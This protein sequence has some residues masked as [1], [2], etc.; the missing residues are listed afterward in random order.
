MVGMLALNMVEHAHA[1]HKGALFGTR[2]AVA[3]LTAREGDTIHP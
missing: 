3:A 1:Q 2:F